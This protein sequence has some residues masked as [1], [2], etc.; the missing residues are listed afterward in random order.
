M[1]MKRAKQACF[2]RQ[3]EKICS[4]CKCV[5]QNPSVQ[6]MLFGKNKHKKLLYCVGDESHLVLE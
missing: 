3:K 6:W 2:T 1:Y 4:F 5:S